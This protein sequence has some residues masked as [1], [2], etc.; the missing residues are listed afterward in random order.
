[1]DGAVNFSNCSFWGNSATLGGAIFNESSAATIVN[2]TFS[3]NTA[4]SG[5]G[6]IGNDGNGTLTIVNAILWGDKQ[7]ESPD[8]I[9]NTG[10]TVT[11][12]Y[13]DIQGG[14]SGTGNIDS[15]PN[16]VEAAKGNLRLKTISPCIDKGMDS[17]VSLAGKDLDDNTRVVHGPCDDLAVVDMGA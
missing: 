12:T 8:E 11:V 2:C 7:G 17:G 5:G 10:G 15:D 1:M 9:E 14:Y 4:S 6:G 16:F 13:S 3:G